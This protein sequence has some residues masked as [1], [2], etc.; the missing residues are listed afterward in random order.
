MQTTPQNPIV[1]KTLRFRWGKNTTRITI[2]STLLLFLFSFSASATQTETLLFNVSAGEFRIRNATTGTPLANTSAHGY[3]E[4]N[5][6]TNT[7]T[8]T[9][10]VWETSARTAL[11]IVGACTL[12]VKG[13]NT[14]TS[15]FSGSVGL[16]SRGIYAESVLVSTRSYTSAL[17]SFDLILQIVKKIYHN[18]IINKCKIK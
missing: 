4:Y 15:T 5:N 14:F 10:F 18:F 3:W 9:D 7:L 1:A 17:S 12:Y 13:T 11:Q 8:L 16:S 2:I 6:A